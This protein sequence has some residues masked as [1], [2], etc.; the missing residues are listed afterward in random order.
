MENSYERRWIRQVKD[1]LRFSMRT[2]R[3]RDSA[4]FSPHN[5]A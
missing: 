1:F 5:D 4:A 2:R 3:R